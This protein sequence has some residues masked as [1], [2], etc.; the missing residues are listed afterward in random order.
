M[1]NDFSSIPVAI[2]LGRLVFENLKKVILYLIPVRNKPPLSIKHPSYVNKNAGRNLC[3]V[4]YSLC[5]CILGHAA[6][7]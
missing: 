6:S 7:A 1:N 5:K 2:E 4:H 3:R